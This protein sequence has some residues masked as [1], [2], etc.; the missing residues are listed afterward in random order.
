MYLSKNNKTT[1]KRGLFIV[2]KFRK[3]NEG[4][5]LAKISVLKYCEYINK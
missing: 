1:Y 5:A 2:L 3:T 4:Y